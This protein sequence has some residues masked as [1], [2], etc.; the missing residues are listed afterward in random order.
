MKVYDLTHKFNIEDMVFPGTPAMSCERTH[1]IEKDQYNLTLVKVNSHAGTHTDAPLHFV[2]GGKALGDVDINRYVGECYVVNLYQK[3]A[4]DEITVEDVKPYEEEIRKAKRVILAT[5]WYEHYNTEEFFTKYPPI[6]VECA[7]YLV[8]LGIVL[9]G[10]DGPSLSEYAGEEVHKLL[11][12]SEV[13]VVESLTNL[14]ELAGKEIIF[15]G[16]PLAFVNMDGFPI[17][18][19]AIEK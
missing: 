14:K 17:R 2:E 12:G 4:L 18:A 5:G 13:A 9:L 7:K 3:G 1:T 15:C 8:S 6:S 11:L 10:V 19:Y 16:A